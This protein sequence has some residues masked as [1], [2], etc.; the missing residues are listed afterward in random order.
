[1][2]V[3][4]LHQEVP[5][6]AAPDERDVLD[7]VAAVSA[8]AL[9][10][11]HV[12]EVFACG[13]DL[14][15]LRDRL[16]RAPPD[17]VVNLVETLGGSGRLAGLVPALLEADGHAFTGSGAFA[18][19]ATSGKGRAKRLLAAAGVPVP[20][21]RV[22]EGGLY[23]VKP[24]W[25]DA[26]IGIDDAA[27]VEG[28]AA[29]EALAAARGPGHL[30][31]RYVEGRE[32][33]VALLETPSGVRVLPPAEIRFEG[34][35][36]GRRRIVGYAAKWAPESFEYQATV[37]SFE[38]PDADAPLLARL[39]SIAE[40]CWEVFGLGGYARVDL[41]VSTAG[42]PWVLEVNANPCLSPDA[43]FAAAL[44]RAGVGYD[45]A[46]AGLL[47]VARHRRR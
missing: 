2:R 42:E 9:R 40:A 28:W 1:M 37:R 41:R 6:D 32:L 17:V 38:L 18:I 45:E 25:E 46:I 16:G 23:I 29:A 14:G 12:V 13:L 24:E 27:V 10:L 44:E 47:E 36:T 26:S 20:P 22:D 21:G 39:A 4:V 33:N 7:E 19:E 15:A 11:G 31:E 3:L 34:D 43:G 35:W 5:A 8:A 30:I